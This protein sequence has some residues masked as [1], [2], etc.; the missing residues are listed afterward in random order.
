LVLNEQLL[1]VI[2]IQNDCVTLCFVQK[3]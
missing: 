3:L 2:R 1:K